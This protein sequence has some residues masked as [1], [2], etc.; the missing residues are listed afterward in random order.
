MPAGGCGRELWGSAADARARVSRL[1]ACPAIDTLQ[2]C[3]EYLASPYVCV[4]VPVPLL[5]DAVPGGRSHGVVTGT[6]DFGV[7]VQFFGGMAGEAGA[8]NRIGCQCAAR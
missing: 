2:A 8:Q 6:A 4:S 5:Q 7:F 3:N 1:I